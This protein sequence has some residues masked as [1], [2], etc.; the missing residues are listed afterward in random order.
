MVAFFAAL[1]IFFLIY[2]HI[3]SKGY[4]S[5]LQDQK[6]LDSLLVSL[7]SGIQAEP[8]E[9]PDFPAKEEE[10][11]SGTVQFPFNPNT[12][13]VDSLELLGIPARLAQRIDNYRQK[14]GVFRKEEDLL[15]IYGFP[16]PLY[17]RLKPSISLPSVKEKETETAFSAEPE[18]KGKE[19]QGLHFDLNKADSLQLRQIRGIGPVLS[20]RIVRFREKLGGFVRME[21][22]YEVYGLD[23]LAVQNLVKS[24]YVE[25]NFVAQQISINSASQEELAAHPYISPAQAR[26]I[27]AFR[28]EHGPFQMINDLGK[29]HTFEHNFVEKIAPYI[30]LD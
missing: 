2:G 19:D 14:G 17:Q 27:F 25:P 26:L 28:T 4:T 12:L 7:E 9:E 15:R 23:S 6:I 18:K 5:Y 20:S 11:S 16:E 22:L 21:Q 8:G 13:S 29:I 1:S 30:R 10:K 24:A 3:P